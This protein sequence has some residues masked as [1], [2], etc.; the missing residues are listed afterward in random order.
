M[1]LARYGRDNMWYRARVLKCIDAEPLTA[2]PSKPMFEVLYLDYGNKEVIPLS[3]CVI[4]VNVLQ[5][6][7]LR[8]TDITIL[9]VRSARLHVPNLSQ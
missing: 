5:N 3:R 7:I 4:V 6:T 1:V 9:P 8:S 2:K